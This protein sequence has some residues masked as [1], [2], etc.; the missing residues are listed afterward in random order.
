MSEEIVFNV[1][2][3]SGRDMTI[4]VDAWDL[5]EQIPEQVRERILEEPATWDIIKSSVKYEIADGFA[6]SNYN[7]PLHDLREMILTSP[8][9]VPPMVVS[10]VSAVLN[11]N[12]RATQKEQD[13]YQAFYRLVRSVQEYFDNYMNAPEWAKRPDFPYDLHQESG[14]ER[15]HVSANDIKKQVMN[16]LSDR[17][18]DSQCRNFETHK[19]QPRDYEF[20]PWC[21]GKHN[22]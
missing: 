16:V 21:G 19:D 5:W 22:R 8:E 12:A 11:E 2:L 6:T 4:S 18:L 10:F 1:K 20:C 3:G 7:K 13:S 17:P 9:M 14:E 15:P